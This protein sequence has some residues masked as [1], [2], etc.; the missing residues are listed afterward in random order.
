M[1]KR[2]KVPNIPLGKEEQEICFEMELITLILWFDLCLGRFIDLLFCAIQE[3]S[4]LATCA[5][6]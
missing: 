3:S 2:R 1:A 4:Y 6:Y 5:R